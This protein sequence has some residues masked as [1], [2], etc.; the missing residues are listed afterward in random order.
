MVARSNRDR[1]WESGTHPQAALNQHEPW[2]GSAAKEQ[3]P[4]EMENKSSVPK[5]IYAGIKFLSNCLEHAAHSFAVVA[6]TSSNRWNWKVTSSQSF[7]SMIEA[8]IGSALKD[9]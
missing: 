1:D 3:G 6:S 8:L 2:E 7:C 4:F 5:Y 9:D